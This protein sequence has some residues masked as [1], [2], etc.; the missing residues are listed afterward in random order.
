MVDITHKSTTL[1]TAVAQAIVKVGSRKTIETIRNGEVPKGNV[2]EISKAAG[3]F[4]AKKT[5]EIIPDCHPLPV[6]STIITHEIHEMSILIKVKIKTV[7]KTGVEVEAMHTASVVALTMY[8][9]LKP[10]DKHV[11]I[12]NIKILLKTGGKAE[13]DNIRDLGLKGSII[14]CSDSVHQGAKID[15]VTDGIKSK[16][17]SYGIEVIHQT[18]LPDSKSVIQTEIKS[19]VQ[20]GDRLIITAGG[21]G[22]TSRDST[23]EALIP[24]LDKRIPGI[25]E[26]MRNFGQQRTPYSMLSR[27]VAG[28]IGQSLIIAMPGSSGGVKESLDVLFPHILHIF[29]IMKVV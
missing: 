26:T 9:M 27:S 3:L 21:T 6:E 24:L 2:F 17:V 25:E 28:I 12:E 8:D 29:R 22:L 14:V 7:Y 16:M 19:R 13:Y 10:I 15:K 23:P 4:A 11:E 5:W 1:R 20:Q 18:V